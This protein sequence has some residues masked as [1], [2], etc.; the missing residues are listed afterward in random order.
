[1]GTRFYVQMPHNTFPDNKV[2]EANVRPSWVLSA[3]DGPHVA[4]MNH[5]ICGP[6]NLHGL[7]LIPAWISNYIHYKEWDGIIYPLLNFNVQPLKFR[8]G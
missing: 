5:A 6:F 4:P 8:N 1:M 2:H 3:P 7:I